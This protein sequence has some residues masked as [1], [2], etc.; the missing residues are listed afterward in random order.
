MAKVRFATR[1]LVFLTM[2][3]LERVR[4]NKGFIRRFREFQKRR[5]IEPAIKC[6]MNGGGTYCGFFTMEDAVKVE[7]WLREQGVEQKSQ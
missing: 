5:G 6:E 2:A 3:G 4:K 1:P 7:R